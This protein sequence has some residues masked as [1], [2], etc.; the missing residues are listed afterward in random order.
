MSSQRLQG[1]AGALEDESRCEGPSCV[2]C[3]DATV[4]GR[5]VELR[6]GGLALVERPGE[7]ELVSVALVEAGPGDTVLIHAGEAIGVV[8]TGD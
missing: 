2:T 7:M 5:V 4:P 6:A 3:S 8:G 1:G